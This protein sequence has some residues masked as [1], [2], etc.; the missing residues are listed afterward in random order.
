[1]ERYVII[2][3]LAT[4]WPVLIVMSILIYRRGCDFCA[5][6][7]GTVLETLM[8]PTVFGWLFGMYAL[9]IVSTAY[10]LK[11]GWYWTVLP[12]FGSFL[13]AIFVVYRAMAHWEKEATELKAFYENLESLVKK[14]TAE[15]EEAHQ[16]SIQHEKEI[17]KLKDQFVFIAAHE[18]KTPV[19]AIRWGIELALEEGKGKLDP[20]L[21]NQ[22]TS[23]QGSNERLITLVDDL[24]NVARIEAG[25]IKMEPADVDIDEIIKET[26]KEMTTVFQSKAISVGYDSKG[27]QTVYADKGRIKQ[28]L[29]NFFS[30]AVKYNKQNGRVTITVEK[31]GNKLKVAVADTGIGIKD[32]DMKKLFTKFGRIESDETADIEGTG[33]GLYVCKEIV[34]KMGGVI[35]AES[36]YGKGSTFIFTVP[37]S[38]MEK[39]STDVE[40]ADTKAG[41]DIH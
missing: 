38:R 37:V 35:Y 16:K 9:G 40:V 14:R 6:L 19:T 27:K 10:M 24:L 39:S 1:M 33:L 20:E 36:E 21:I 34:S 11:I 2:F 17:Q 28:V 3:I 22:L 4:G 25:T 13:I 7:R 12:A 23:I 32:E 41:A 30:N 31:E 18:L 5:K 8:K 29:I 15:L 26:I